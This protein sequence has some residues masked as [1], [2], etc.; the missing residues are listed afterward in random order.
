MAARLVDQSQWQIWGRGQGGMPPSPLIFGKKAEKLKMQAKKPS[1]LPLS[2]R[3]GFA[4]ESTHFLCI[5]ILF[6]SQT[7]LIIAVKVA[8]MSL[9]KLV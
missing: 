2:S 4:T 3:S 7:L 9:Q 1:P 8:Y 5:I 6:L